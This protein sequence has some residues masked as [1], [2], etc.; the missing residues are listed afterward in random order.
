MLVN[1]RLCVTTRPDGSRSVPHLYS[2]HKIFSTW[3]LCL[4][5]NKAWGHSSCTCWLTLRLFW[6]WL[7]F[8]WHDFFR[9]MATVYLNCIKQNF[10]ISKFL[11]KKKKQTKYLSSLEK[12]IH[13]HLT[14]ID[15]CWNLRTKTYS[16]SKGFSV[17]TRTLFKIFILFSGHL[18]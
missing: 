9:F 2:I 6:I 1:S 16:S 15:I 8:Y 4:Y 10:S 12:I 13:K 5:E 17:S 14:S 3:C 7:F 18:E 11:K